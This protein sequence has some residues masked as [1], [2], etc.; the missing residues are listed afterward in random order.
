MKMYMCGH[1]IE[2]IRVLT[3]EGSHVTKKGEGAS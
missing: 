2:P 3:T 1:H